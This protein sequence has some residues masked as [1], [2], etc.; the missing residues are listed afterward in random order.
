MRR[1]RRRSRLPVPDRLAAEERARVVR[2]LD[3]LAFNLNTIAVAL[4]VAGA[5]AC[6]DLVNGA[7]EK[8][9]AACWLLSSPSREG[10]P[11]GDR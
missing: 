7:A 4:D 8:L 2:E 3:T 9:A 1:S 6:S 10:A 11:A 5:G